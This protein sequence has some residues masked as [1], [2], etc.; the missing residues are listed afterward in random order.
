MNSVYP[1]S[2]FLFVYATLQPSEIAYPRVERFVDAIFEI[3]DE[4]FLGTRGISGS[5][6]QSLRLQQSKVRVKSIVT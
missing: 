5:D 3:V 1:E 6:F 4:N 2:S